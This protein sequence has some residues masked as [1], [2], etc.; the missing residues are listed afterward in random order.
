MQEVQSEEDK[1]EALDVV[2]ENEKIEEGM[3][4]SIISVKTETFLKKRR[5]VIIDVDQVS[6]NKIYS[7]SEDYNATKL[8]NK[9][10]ATHN[11]IRD[12]LLSKWSDMTTI[13]SDKMG[14]Q[15]IKN[16]G[17]NNIKTENEVLLFDE[18]LEDGRVRFYECKVLHKVITEIT[19]PWTEN[20]ILYND[21]SDLES[22]Q[23]F[24]RSIRNLKSKDPKMSRKDDRFYIEGEPEHMENNMNDFLLLDSMFTSFIMGAAIGLILGIFGFGLFMTLATILSVI[25]L[26]YIRG[27]RKAKTTK[28]TKSYYMVGYNEELDEYGFNVESL[29]NMTVLDEL[30][31]TID[32][33]VNEG[34]EFVSRNRDATWELDTVDNTSIPSESSSKFIESLGIENISEDNTF[35]AKIE[36]RKA[37]PDDYALRSKCGEWYLYPEPIY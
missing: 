24:A 26:D 25:V 32:I 21:F 31:D 9:K 33:N 22:A 30:N 35:M 18:V 19:D 12:S 14:S 27:Y 16:A 5:E 23:N 11:E 7:K 29:D 37:P 20:R 3:G 34:M 1:K 17:K 36:K 2:F 15:S 28:N 10:Y 8:E 4:I 13:V 6:N